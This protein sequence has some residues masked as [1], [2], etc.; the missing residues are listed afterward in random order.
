MTDEGELPLLDCPSVNRIRVF[1]PSHTI[2][3]LRFSP[4]RTNLAAERK[5][6]AQ[7]QRRQYRLRYGHFVDHICI[8]FLMFALVILDLVLAFDER[9]SMFYL[10]ATL[11]IVIFYWFEIV[12]RMYAYTFFVYFSNIFDFLDFFIVL[13]SIAIWA[14]YLMHNIRYFRHFTGKKIH[15]ILRASRA[16]FKLLMLLL[17]LPHVCRSVVAMNKQGVSLGR[18]FIDLCYITDRILAMGLPASGIESCWRNSMTDVA[19][20]LNLNHFGHY[21]VIDLCEER[22]YSH[23]IFEGRVLRSPFKDHSIPPLG[24][25]VKIVHFCLHFLNADPN[26]VVVIHCKGGKGRTGLVVVSLMSV[27]YRAS[28]SQLL[29]HFAKMRTDQVL[30]GGAQAVSNASQIRYV[31]YVHQLARKDLDQRNRFIRSEPLYLSE[32]DAGFNITSFSFGPLPPQW[33]STNFSRFEIQLSNCSDKKDVQAQA[34][35]FGRNEAAEGHLDSEICWITITCARP[36]HCKG[37][38][39]I[40]LCKDRQRFAGVLIHTFMEVPTLGDVGYYLRYTK[41]EMDGV[42]YSIIPDDFEL[43]LSLASDPSDIEEP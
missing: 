6:R 3:K 25:L 17:R 36:F 22:E 26:N 10:Y 12:F 8:F 34:Y 20:Y 39:F 5:A 16:I 29:R 28:V 15:K 18:K 31:Q 35:L 7:M 33:K 30:S 37:N 40:W 4:L 2:A 24:V 32:L 19:K 21:Y 42:K 41:N 1:N 43:V 14:L 9:E 13:F 38:L 23:D 27:I 11:V